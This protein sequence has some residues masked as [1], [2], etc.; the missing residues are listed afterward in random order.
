[1]AP[2]SYYRAKFKPF[3][4]GFSQKKFNKKGGAKLKKEGLLF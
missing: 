2:P 3:N 4:L 1:L